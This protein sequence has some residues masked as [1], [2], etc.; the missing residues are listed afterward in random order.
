LEQR[1][2]I[3]ELSVITGSSLRSYKRCLTLFIFLQSF[4]YF[5]FERAHFLV[6]LYDMQQM[7]S[8]D[9]DLWTFAAYSKST[10][11]TFIVAPEEKARQEKGGGRVTTI[12]FNETRVGVFLWALRSP[13]ASIEVNKFYVLTRV[14]TIIIFLRHNYGFFTESYVQGLET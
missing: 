5:S 1:S 10:F 13:H 11:T 8:L 7:G 12:T 9:G 3:T 2:L 14:L 6:T 4:L